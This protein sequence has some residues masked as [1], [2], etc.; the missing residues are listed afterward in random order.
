MDLVGKEV[1]AVG[2]TGRADLNG[3]RGFV[4]EYIDAKGRCAVRFGGDT[5]GVLIK[6]INLKL[7]AVDVSDTSAAA[8]QGAPADE[9][10]EALIETVQ[11]LRLKDSKATV[12]E[13]HAALT[14]GEWPAVSLGDVKKAASKATKRSAR[15]APTEHSTP[16]TIAPRGH[17]IVPF[18]VGSIV[19]DLNG[20]KLK[21]V[22]SKAGGLVSVLAPGRQRLELAQSE[23]ILIDTPRNTCPRAYDLIV[24]S[25]RIGAI[26]QCDTLVDLLAE[27][28]APPQMQ[29]RPWDSFHGFAQRCGGSLECMISKPEIAWLVP[30]GVPPA[31][32][33]FISFALDAVA[34]HLVIEWR[35]GHGWRLLQSY[36][37]P[38]RTGAL[39]DGRGYTALEWATSARPCGSADPSVHARLGQGKWL[40][41]DEIRGYLRAIMRLRT[42][43]D[44]IVIK[45]LLPQTPW[46]KQAGA[47]PKVDPQ[48]CRSQAELDT[49]QAW[50]EAVQPV[51]EWA[52]K[53]IAVAEKRGA[54]II[55]NKG[56]PVEILIGDPV[57]AGELE[58]LLA[59]P[60]A[61]ANE[62]DAAYA[63]VTGEAFSAIHYLRLLN[64]LESD[65]CIYQPSKEERERERERQLE[66]ERLFKVSVLAQGAGALMGGHG[67]GEGERTIRGWAVRCIHWGED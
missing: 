45:Y 9:S 51:G 27:R 66:R 35:A 14:A 41:D 21:V 13:L 34:H 60:E 31:V 40:K 36:L 12:K 48:T 44:A 24:Q 54:T 58:P 3:Q 33:R 64:Y 46:G 10:L 62:I 26:D 16:A 15:L 17:L 19:T 57:A 20:R 1:E 67:E 29:L 8:P 38:E 32:S 61:A 53:K 28:A 2:L 42:L 6:P 56:Q 39:Y 55:R 25:P 37:K 30:T 18:E 11:Q 49:L 52:A 59:V 7:L 5:E 63:A 22:K 50:M 23:L 43:A 47:R 4:L 65:Y